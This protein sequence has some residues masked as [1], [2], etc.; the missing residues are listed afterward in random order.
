MPRRALDSSSLA[1]VPAQQPKPS[2][3]TRAHQLAARA[4]RAHEDPVAMTSDATLTRLAKHIAT[5]LK[6]NPELTPLQAANAG[7]LLLRAE[8]AKLAEASAKARRERA[9]L[10]ATGLLDC[11]EQ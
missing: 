5:A 2:H 10:D 7:R 8:M 3:L 4:G 11:G 6:K 1:P 9:G